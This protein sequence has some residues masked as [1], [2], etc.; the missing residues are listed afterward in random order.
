M[1]GT[2]HK[3][4]FKWFLSPDLKELKE[5]FANYKRANRLQQI[6]KCKDDIEKYKKWILE[7]EE[8]LKRLEEE[9]DQ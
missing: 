3:L 7:S 2:K 4:K 9:E 8:T 1:E 6:D 5:Y